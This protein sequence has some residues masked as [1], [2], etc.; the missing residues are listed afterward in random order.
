MRQPILSP[1]RFAEWF[2]RVVPAYRKI[3]PEDARYLTVVG[4]VGRYGY[5]GRTDLEIVRSILQYEQMREE[6]L[7][8]YNK[9]SVCKMCGKPLIPLL[10]ARKG[11]P[12]EYCAA[13]NPL[14][15]RDRWRKW[16]V[17][18]KSAIT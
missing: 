16:Q 4:L 15:P 9:Q 8:R 5:Y 1:D 10:N 6:R 2:N 13:C 7:S 11:R 14:R 17:K 3:T 18:M 12:K